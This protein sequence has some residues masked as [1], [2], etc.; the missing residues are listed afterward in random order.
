MSHLVPSLSLQPFAA[1]VNN[2]GYATVV[3]VEFDSIQSIRVSRGWQS[4]FMHSLFALAWAHT[5]V[6]ACG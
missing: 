3:P 5:L 6:V 4:N 2:A 1:L